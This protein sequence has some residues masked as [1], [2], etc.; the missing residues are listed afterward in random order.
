[1]LFNT[2]IVFKHYL[3]QGVPTGKI[4][5]GMPLYSCTFLKTAGPG[6]SFNGVREADPDHGS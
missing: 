3:S 5:I 6:S 2:D 1:M 4:V